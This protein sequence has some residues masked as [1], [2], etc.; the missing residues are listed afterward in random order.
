MVILNDSNAPV[1]YY[2]RQTMKMHKN[3]V[4]KKEFDRAEA[5]HSRN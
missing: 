2:R 4:A 1:A 5:G 3:F